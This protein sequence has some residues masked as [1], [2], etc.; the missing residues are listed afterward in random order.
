MFEF[1]FFNAR[2]NNNRPL[3]MMIK[4]KLCHDQIVTNVIIEEEGSCLLDLLVVKNKYNEVH[5]YLW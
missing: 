5:F 4:L 1:C 3:P 2:K